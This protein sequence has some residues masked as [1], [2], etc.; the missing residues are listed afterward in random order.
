MDDNI[1][2]VIEG[3]TNMRHLKPAS[4]SDIIAAEIRLNLSFADEYKE[5]V[6]EYGVITAKSIEITGICESPRLS[7]AD[8]TLKERD[9]NRNLPLDLYVIE[10]TD[11]EGLL[12]VQDKK[13]IIYSFTS[14]GVLKKQYQSL[15]D[16]L[17][18]TQQA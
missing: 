5:Y 10:S 6:K 2:S 18:S 12:I 3:L 8:V 11:F 14:D 15:A 16:Y 13:G 4:Q 1:I 9:L 7:V 17:Q